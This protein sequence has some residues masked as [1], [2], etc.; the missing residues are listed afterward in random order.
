MSNMWYVNVLIA[1]A[2]I[3]HFSFTMLIAFERVEQRLS[4]LL[5]LNGV[6]DMNICSVKKTGSIKLNVQASILFYS[7]IVMI[8]NNSYDTSHKYY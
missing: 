1:L 7:I 4:L 5:N 8:L 2:F 3:L 6:H